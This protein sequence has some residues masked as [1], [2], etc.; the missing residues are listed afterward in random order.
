MM[1]RRAFL[2]LLTGA[3]ACPLA[4]RA[5]QP[6]MPVI[7]YLGSGSQGPLRHQVA[8]FHQG[9]NE[10]GFAGRRNVTIEY[11]WAEGQYNRLP[12][13]AADLV[14]RQGAV[15]AAIGGVQ[16]ALA[17]KAAASSIPIVFANGS[18]P[19]VFGLVASL[20][21]PGGN[22]TGVSFL[23]DG[24]EAKR[25]G[26]LR[27]LVPQAV[28]LAALV[29]PNFPNFDTQSKELNAAARMLGVQFHIVNA[30]QDSDFDIAFT[31]LGQIR[32]G[33]LV[34]AA[35]PF[36]NSRREQIVALAI[37]QRFRRCTNDANLPK[38][39]V[40]RAMEPAWPM[41]TIRLAPTPGVFSRAR[42]RPTCQ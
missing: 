42:S 8:A 24:L 2:S 40:W 33:G 38:P 18:D 20:N 7:G 1:R 28:V 21:R 30:G 16:T 32:A 41:H 3:A 26:L 39:A 4:A 9:L 22:M 6:A 35:D 13:L 27:E 15:I 36:F 37:R 5:Q 29:N 19:V 31:T 34:V 14:R 12:E 10:N 11:R 23:T 25:L 17:A